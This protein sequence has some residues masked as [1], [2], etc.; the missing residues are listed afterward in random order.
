MSPLKL[1]ALG[2]FANRYGSMTPPSWWATLHKE[3]DALNDE[4]EELGLFMLD[5]RIAGMQALR[6][7]W[8]RITNDD[9]Y[10]EPLS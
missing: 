9:P 8:Y 2:R 5:E 1:T 7:G 6:V 10:Y 3:I 4:D